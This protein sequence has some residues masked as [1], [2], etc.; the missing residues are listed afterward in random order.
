MYI[1][2]KRLT[3]P[4]IFS[5]FTFNPQGLEARKDFIDKHTLC[6]FYDG[7]PQKGVPLFVAS[8]QMSIKAVRKLH[9]HSS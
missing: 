4:K 1:L 5:S 6:I 3:M 8:M 9:F 2:Q 7:I